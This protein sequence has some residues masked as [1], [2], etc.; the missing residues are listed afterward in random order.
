MNTL[1]DYLSVDRISLDLKGETKEEVLK[2]LAL[3]LGDSQYIGDPLIIE[4]A[5]NA[6]EEIGSTGI[7]KH[8]A[9]PHAKTEHAK[10]L[11]IGVG[12][13]I[14]GV[15]FDSL[16]KEDV[17][18]FFVFAS[19]MHECNL[20]LKALAKVS[21]LVR[22]DAFREKLMLARDPHEFLKILTESEV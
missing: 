7:G 12:R 2:E 17:N 19:P 13:S 5:L 4:K 6:R 22:E 1:C 14:A 8:V 18:L 3:L 10:H 9:I 16:D 11:T 21:K 15:D 20:Y